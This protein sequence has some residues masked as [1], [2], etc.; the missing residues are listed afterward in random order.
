MANTF[1]RRPFNVATPNKNDVANQFMTQSNWKGVIKNKNFL[2]VDQ[3]SF[4]DALNVYVDDEYILKSRP[5]VKIKKHVKINGVEHKVKTVHSFSN[6][7]DVILTSNKFCIFKN[8]DLVTTIGINDEDDYRLLQV[9]DSILLFTKSNVRKINYDGTIT[10]AKIYVPKTKLITL[11]GEEE[12]LES[13]NIFTDDEIIVYVYNSQLSNPSV[14]SDLKGKH[15][16]LEYDNQIIEF[17][18]SENL[19]QILFKDFI[20]LNR[21]ILIS[22]NHFVAP[23]TYLPFAISS[24][25]TYAYYDKTTQEIYYSVDGKIFSPITKIPPTLLFNDTDAYYGSNIEIKFCR[26]NPAILSIMLK[27]GDYVTSEG[28]DYFSGALYMISVE[29]DMPDGSF[30]YKNLTYI[31]S[32]CHQYKINGTCSC[33]FDVLDYN[34]YILQNITYGSDGKIDFH[35]FGKDKDSDVSYHVYN[36]TEEAK[37]VYVNLIRLT[38]NGIIIVCDRLI[39]ESNLSYNKS[40]KF[41][42]FSSGDTNPSIYESISDADADLLTLGYEVELLDDNRFFIY[43]IRRDPVDATYYDGSKF[44]AVYCPYYGIKGN[45]GYGVNKQNKLFE[46]DFTNYSWIAKES[47][48]NV[49]ANNIYGTRYPIQNEGTYFYYTIVTTDHVILRRNVID[50]TV[51]LEYELDKVD[52]L[53]FIPKHISQLKNMYISKGNEL[54]ISQITNENSIYFPESNK[55]LFTSNITNL[56]PLSE[57]EMGIFLEDEIWYSSLTE[58]GYEYRKSRLDFGCSEGTEVETSFDGKYT[59]FDTDRGFAA[60]SYQDFI[61]STEQSVTFISDTIESMYKNFRK[62]HPVK[63]TKFDNYLF[64]Y[65]DNVTT[66]DVLVYDFRTASWWPWYIRDF[67]KILRFNDELVIIKEDRFCNFY[68]G[69]NSYYDYAGVKKEQKI[70]WRIKSQKLHLNANNYDKHIINMTFFTVQNEAVYES[71]T[72]TFGTKMV[73][74]PFSMKLNITNYRHYVDVVKEESFEYK[75]EVIRTFVKRLNFAK[76]REFQYE[77]SSDLENSIL[78]PLSFSAI[79]IKYKIGGQVR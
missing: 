28:V 75:V 7:I 27:D 63:L 18:F 16:K 55:R 56:H 13:K 12:E 69:H 11:T 45:Y 67:T 14:K 35:C 47:L 50:E 5:S 33:A 36:F 72:S 66:N 3:E 79:T 70:S 29:S 37:H 61:A 49:N 60:L 32:T 39:N 64:L 1:N 8:D 15:V 40:F 2:A 78:L 25:N 41:Y 58:Q 6:G 19:S 10:K 34:K 77:L 23:Y 62:R 21:D 74:I 46:F 4:E 26:E 57:S 38:K 17:D 30:R 76:V 48:L 24:K 71:E 43:N 31:A 22:K 59:L 54:Y 65:K 52:K 51:N 53:L 44:E 73:M 20:T 42:T 68:Y 9:D